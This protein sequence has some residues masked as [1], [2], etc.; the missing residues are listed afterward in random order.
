MVQKNA[1]KLDRRA[2]DIFASEYVTVGNVFYAVNISLSFKLFHT[3][4]SP[5]SPHKINIYQYIM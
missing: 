5:T 4:K 1:H 2:R 3:E